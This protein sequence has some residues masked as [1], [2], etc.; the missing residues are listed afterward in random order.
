MSKKVYDPDECAAYGECSLL[1]ENARE[2]ISSLL[3]IME[4]DN[5]LNPNVRCKDDSITEPLRNAYNALL[6]YRKL[7]SAKTMGG[8]YENVYYGDKDS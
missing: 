7:I 8:W 1:A 3:E 2:T 4:S 5:E 6:E